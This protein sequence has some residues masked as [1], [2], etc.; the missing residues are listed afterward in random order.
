MRMA[1]GPLE[2]ESEIKRL[3]TLRD[4]WMRAPDSESYGRLPVEIIDLERRRVNMSMSSKEILIDD[5]CPC[6]VALAQDFDTPM[7]WHL[8]GC[9]MDDGFVFSS[10]KTMEEWETHNREMDEFNRD[11]E[12]KQKEDPDWWKAGA[13]PF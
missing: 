5:N 2:I 11:F 4:E 7:F 9:N 6:C 8:D 3:S 12:R 1:G 10:F 13:N